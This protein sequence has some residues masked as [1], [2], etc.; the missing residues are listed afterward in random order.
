M[1]YIA[2]E[3]KFP[4]DLEDENWK[5]TNE[6]LSIFQI[7]NDKVVEN[8]RWNIYKSTYFLLG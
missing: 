2:I 8:I 4:I 6:V 3:S 5:D 1:V 7:N